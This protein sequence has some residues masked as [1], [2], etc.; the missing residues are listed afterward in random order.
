MPKTV[1]RDLRERPLY[2][3]AEA[4]RY[5]RLPK[6]TVRAWVFG[7]RG[8]KPVVKSAD[9]AR[10]LLSFLNLVELMVLGSIRR[11]HRVTLRLVRQGVAYLQRV[12]PSTHP[13]ADHSFLTDE[14]R[15]YVDKFGQILD[16]TREGQ[17]VIREAIEEALRAVERDPAGVPIKLYLPQSERAAPARGA[18]VIDPRVGFGRPVID[19]TGI[20]T[21]I[22][23]SRFRAGEPIESLARDYERRREEIEE[24]VR[25]EIPLAA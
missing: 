13:L 3:P 25:G 8:F 15:L 17:I 4:A 12:F 18:V 19:G 24:I 7:Q 9:P 14:T 2:T 22:V 1:L 16:V 6:S 10:R 20:R 23:V 11:K 21:E 5:L